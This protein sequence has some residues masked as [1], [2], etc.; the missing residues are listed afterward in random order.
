MQRQRVHSA[1]K[2]IGQQGVDP[3]VSLYPGKFSELFSHYRELEMGICCRTAVA[4]TLIF[5]GQVLRMQI[6]RNL[7]FDARLNIHNSI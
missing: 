5:Y 4:V 7:V 3:L 1:G 2:L 6:L